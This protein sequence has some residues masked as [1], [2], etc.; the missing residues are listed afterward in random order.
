MN[1]LNLR[2]RNERDKAYGIAGMAIT[3]VACDGEHLMAEIHLDA[4]PAHCMVMRHE[5]CM[6][7]NPRMS[8]KVV[9]SQSIKDLKA[10]TSMMLGN[11]ACRRYILDGKSMQRA[12]ADAIRS[13][14]RSEAMDWCDLEE[15]E[16]D[17]LFDTCLSYATRIF[18]HYGMRH[19]ADGFVDRLT[20]RRDMSA[21]EAIELLASLGLR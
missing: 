18:S 13:L 14:V 5:H 21:G 3:L 10:I 4:D 9:W 12:E 2:Y 7:S 11:L 6:K 20:E 1:E 8:A 19:V 17:T 16:A 15:D